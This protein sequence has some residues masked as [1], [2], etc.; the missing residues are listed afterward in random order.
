M[1]NS[2]IYFHFVAVR[3]VESFV[4][5]SQLHFLGSIETTCLLVFF[6]LWP[7][8]LLITHL[9]TSLLIYF[10]NVRQTVKRDPTVFRLIFSI[11][12]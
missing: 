10:I 3:E 7:L 4:A 6:S 11:I 1:Y 12:L 2:F 5:G 9:F 8:L